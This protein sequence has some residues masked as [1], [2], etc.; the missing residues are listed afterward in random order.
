MGRQSSSNATSKNGAEGTGEQQHR[1]AFLIRTAEGV[2]YVFS[3][4]SDA[5]RDEWIKVLV[6]LEPA[7]GSAQPSQLRERQDSTHSVSSSLSRPSP[8][9]LP[10][11]NTVSPTPSSLGSGPPA[12]PPRSSTDRNSPARRLANNVSVP[13][14][15][16]PLPS[17]FDFKGKNNNGASRGRDSVVEKKAKGNKSFWGFSSNRSRELVYS[18][19]WSR[20]Q[21]H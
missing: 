7:A 20:E 2:D 10:P 19:L 16:M 5:A 4:D 13:T 21:P 9:L 14:N 15:A 6:S 1:H 12:L 8:P 17:G 3:A 11:R 18:V